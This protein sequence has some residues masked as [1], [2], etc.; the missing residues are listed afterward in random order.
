M[1]VL[2]FNEKEQRFFYNFGSH[3]LNHNGWR[4]LAFCH[5][6]RDARKQFEKINYNQN[7]IYKFDDLKEQIWLH[8]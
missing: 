7:K 4:S 1:V 3:R 8:K 5:T 6:L 2:E